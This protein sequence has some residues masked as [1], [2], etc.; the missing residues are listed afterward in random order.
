MTRR[1]KLWFALASIFTFVNLGGAG[2][3]V[4]GAEFPHAA[5]HAALAVVGT[6]FMWRFAARARA[7]PPQE[8]ALDDARL[9]TL[10]QSLDSIAL[11]VERI[12]EA[13]RFTAKLM[14]ER[15]EKPPTESR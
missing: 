13:Q 15:A 2:F 11:E 7:R 4:A 8:A 9:D 12:G 10:Q 5:V 3:A 14:A 1:P 6:F